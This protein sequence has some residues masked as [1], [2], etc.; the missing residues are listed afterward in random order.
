[1]IVGTCVSLDLQ[2]QLFRWIEKGD[3]VQE[4]QTECGYHGHTL[5]LHMQVGFAVY[6]LSLRLSGMAMRTGGLL[7][8]GTRIFC[9]SAQY[10]VRTSVLRVT[11]RTIFIVLG[12]ALGM[13]S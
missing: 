4:L 1:M 9:C 8:G 5:A 12:S 10:R 2:V 6:A 3:G 7:P 13:Y 11:Q